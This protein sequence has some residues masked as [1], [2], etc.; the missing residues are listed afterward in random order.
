[1]KNNMPISNREVW[2]D[3]VKVFACILVVLGHFFQSMTKANILSSNSLYSWFIQTIYMFHVPLFFVCS[4][5]LYQKSSRVDTWNAW[6][7]NMAKKALSLGIPYV[8]FSLIT[9][10]L[11]TVF[12]S[13]VNEQIDGLFT[14]LF[15]RPTSPYWYLYCL[16]FV[17]LITPTF[18]NRRSAVIGLLIAVLFKIFA[19]AGFGTNIYATQVVL[20]NEFWFVLGMCLCLI[21]IRR[22]FKR[23]TS[24]FMGFS[25]LIFFVVCSVL[26]WK[27]VREVLY[28]LFGVVACVATVLCFGY[29]FRDN[30]QNRLFGIGAKYTMPIFLMHT[31][32]AAGLRI[33]LL[34]MGIMNEIVHVTLGLTISFLGPIIAAMIMKKLKCLEF[35]IYPT[36][37]IKFSKKVVD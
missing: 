2:V 25:M 34:K 19:L 30:M 14:I 13:S 1:M 22:F 35:F 10:A 36:K 9:W 7:T 23:K 27:D 11:K 26:R 33:V 17:F 32:F 5:Y 24:F 28:F 37:Y 21:D 18:R 29:L 20:G 15:I 12:S 6:V 3:N 4:G 16:F 31:I 8:V